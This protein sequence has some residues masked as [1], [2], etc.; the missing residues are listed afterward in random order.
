MVEEEENY[1]VESVVE[2]IKIFHQLP[3]FICRLPFTHM[4]FSS[5]SNVESVHVQA[6]IHCFGYQFPK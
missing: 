4:P 5:I 1:Y 6:L 3:L 2:L